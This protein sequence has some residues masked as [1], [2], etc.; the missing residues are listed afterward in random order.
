M[1]DRSYKFVSSNPRSLSE[2]KLSNKM[3]RLEPG[4]LIRN[5]VPFVLRT[6]RTPCWWKWPY[7]VLKS[8]PQEYGTLRTPYSPCPV[9]KIM[10]VLRTEI[11][12]P[13]VPYSACSVLPV[14]RAGNYHRTP[15]EIRT[16]WQNYSL[17]SVLSVLYV[18]LY[19]VLKKWPYPRIKFV[20]RIL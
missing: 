8:V 12:T 18:P 13:I 4:M 5:F 3:S 6:P 14:L 11:R 9:L 2:Q 10:T 16:P 7:P 17:Y 15:C 1:K 19:F 20:L